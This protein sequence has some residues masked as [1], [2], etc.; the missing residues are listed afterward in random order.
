M[1]EYSCNDLLSGISTCEG[2]V[3]NGAQIDTSSTGVKSFGVSAEDAA[4]N[5]SQSSFNYAVVYGIGALYDPTKAVKAGGT[6]PIR[7]QLLDANGLNHSS[8]SITV[9]AI[10]V[11]QV[12]SQ[13]SSSVDSSGSSNPDLNF[14]FD[15][16]LNGY[17]FNLKTSGLSTGSYL[18][19]YVVGDS[20]E[21][22][23]TG[24][25]VRQ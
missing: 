8:P 1:S 11:V 14:R 15:A 18:L 5:S 2:T 13:A 6:V 19:R 17:V 20:A 23:S 22:Y 10:S 21:V 7:I 24:F 3:A 9:T 4:G 25:Q 16:A 12:S